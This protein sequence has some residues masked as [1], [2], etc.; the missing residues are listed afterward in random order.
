MAAGAQRFSF[1]WARWLTIHTLQWFKVLL[2]HCF[3]WA[4]QQGTLPGLTLHCSRHSPRQLAY[5]TRAGNNC[6]KHDDN[7]VLV[8]C[9]YVLRVRVQHVRAEYNHRR[10]LPARQMF[11]GYEQQ[12]GLAACARLSEERSQAVRREERI[13]VK[14]RLTDFPFIPEET[15]TSCMCTEDATVCTQS[16]WTCTS[17][18]SNRS[19]SSYVIICFCKSLLCLYT[20]AFRLKAKSVKEKSETCPY[21]LGDIISVCLADYKGAYYRLFT[22]QNKTTVKFRS[23]TA[24]PR[25]TEGVE[26][27]DTP[28]TGEAM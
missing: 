4:A 19:Q 7:V 6:G 8:R 18:F 27:L 13:G 22:K 1:Y 20:A 28:S 5:S 25:R 15:N 12:R 9:S 11:R 21:H 2:I 3:D 26:L 10:S 16:L 24:T 23:A 14:T 17:G